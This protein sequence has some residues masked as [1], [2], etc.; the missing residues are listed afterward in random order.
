MTFSNGRNDYPVWS[1]DGKSIAYAS[2]RSG[3]LDLYRKNADGSGEEILLLKS[4][5]D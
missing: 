4:D 2:N 1:P 5:Q 3:H